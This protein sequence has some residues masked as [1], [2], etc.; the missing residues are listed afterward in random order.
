MIEHFKKRLIS[1]LRLFRRAPK[2]QIHVDIPITRHRY[3]LEDLDRHTSV[4]KDS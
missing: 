2:R 1:L 4:D 3:R